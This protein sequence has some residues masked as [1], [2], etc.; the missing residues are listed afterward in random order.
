MGYHGNHEIEHKE[1]I[2]EDNAVLYS[3]GLIE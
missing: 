3:G 1:L 2:F